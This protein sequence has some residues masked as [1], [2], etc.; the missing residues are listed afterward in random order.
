MKSKPSLLWFYGIQEM[1]FCLLII[2]LFSDIHVHGQTTIGNMHNVKNGFRAPFSLFSADMDKDGFPDVVSG[3]LHDSLVWFKNDGHANYSGPMLIGIADNFREVFAADIDGDDDMDVLAAAKNDKAVV[4][5]KNDGNQ[6]FEGPLFIDNEAEHIRFVAAYDFDID[7][8]LD[9]I[10]S[11]Y[12]QI[13]LY[14]NDGNGNFLQKHIVHNTENIKLCVADANGDGYPDIFTR[15]SFADSLVWLK[16][17]GG[18][19]FTEMHIATGHDLEYIYDIAVCDM[20]GDGLQ[21]FLATFIVDTYYGYIGYYKNHGDGNFQFEKRIALQVEEFNRL[22]AADLDGNGEGEVFSYSAFRDELYYHDLYSIQ[23]GEVIASNVW[24]YV[25]FDIDDV[26]GDGDLDFMVSSTYGHRIFWF[27]T[28]KLEILEQP[29]DVAE[30]ARGTAMF[31]IQPKDATRISW[32]V[33]YPGKSYFNT[34]DKYDQFFEGFDS[35]TLVIPDVVPELDSTLYRCII[36]NDA[37]SMYSDT[38]MLSLV[39]D[40]IPPELIVADTLVHLNEGG[41]ALI[42][43]NQIIKSIHDDCGFTEVDIS[44]LQLSCQHTG[45]TE[46]QIT[47]V[48]GMG[49]STTQTAFVEV[50]D[51]INP[52]AQV[53]TGQKFFSLQSSYSITEDLS[54]LKLAYDNCGI[55]SITNNVNNSATLNGI[56]LNRGENPITWTIVDF[57]GNAITVDQIIELVTENEYEIF[58]NPFHDWI[59][60]KQAYAGEYKLKITSIEGKPIM[61]LEQ[62]LSPEISINLMQLSRG[63]YYL[64][65]DNGAE[66]Q[67]FKLVKSE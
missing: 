26:D 7:G 50:V 24:E 35:Q 9:V 30:C 49:N 29:A 18:F 28:L 57:S 25:D 10:S 64:T 60:I 54:G 53:I 13:A 39:L 6:N 16:N 33:R 65:I 27:E 52:V 15:A 22:A 41:L 4:W 67:L 44:T 55:A 12:S 5:F 19:S 36:F 40:T 43:K 59:T 8:D 37:G 38:V 61:E 3:S 31:S 11:Y 17:N 62:I 34:I 47:A 51:S 45:V 23:Y 1:C 2:A 58:P 66:T 56:V 42:D 63:I 14:E 21:D 20:N 48:D 32:Q 46:V